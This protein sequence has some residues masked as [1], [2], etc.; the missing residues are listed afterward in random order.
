MAACA[1]DLAPAHVLEFGSRDI[2]GGV[3]GLFLSA[4]TYTGVDLHDGPSVDVVADVRYYTHDRLVDVVVS[5]ELLEHVEHP[6]LVVDAAY[7]NL[8]RPGVFIAT[9][10]GVHRPP[11]GA[12]GSPKPAPG[13][14]YDNISLE[15]LTAA[16]GDAGF[17]DWTVRDTGRDI[18]C[19]AHTR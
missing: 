12:D 11:H 2:N 1:S 5:T 14:W 4:V 10:A 18:Y 6:E 3:R 19:E 9:A 7:R 17:D 16:L 13:E 8:R 15:Q